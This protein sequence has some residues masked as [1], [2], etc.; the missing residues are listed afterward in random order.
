MSKKDVL[1]LIILIALIIAIITIIVV[2]RMQDNTVQVNEQKEETNSVQTSPIDTQYEKISSASWANKAWL[3]KVDVSTITEINF[4]NNYKGSLANQAWVFDGLRCYYRDGVIYVVVGDS[5][6]IVGSM[7]GAFSDLTALMAINGLDLIDTSEVSD[8]SNLLKNCSSLQTFDIENLETDGVVLAE[9]MF[10]GCSSLID[11]DMSGKNM[12]NAVDMDRMY[13]QCMSLNT[14]HLPQTESVMSLSGTFENVGSS[15]KYKTKIIGVLNTR[16][17]EDMN[18]MFKNAS[19]FDYEFVQNFNTDSLRTATGMFDGSCI[20][21]IDLSNWNVSKLE[22]TEDMFARCMSL[23]NIKTEGWSVVS[24]K[25]CNGMF[26]YC[27]GIENIA[28]R[29]INVPS[30]I[31]DSAHMFRNCFHLLTIDISCFDNVHFNNATEMFTGCESVTSIYANN[32]SADISDDMFLYCFEI[33]G[34]MT[35]QENALDVG[36]ANTNGYF[37]G[38]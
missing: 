3:G 29:W 11:L 28:L 5:L 19:I 2:V 12:K 36:M 23:K 18:Y 4:V 17:C 31:Q 24:L 37:K 14:L 34:A 38:K 7:N 6:K 16:Q 30:V 33:S 9:G 1:A 25:N 20:E 15:S 32:F 22:I 21:N 8:M 27:T 35:Y 26:F 10:E 13:A